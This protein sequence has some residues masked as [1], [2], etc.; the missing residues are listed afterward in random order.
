[1]AAEVT[2][3]DGFRVETIAQGQG[4]FDAAPGVDAN[5]D[6]RVDPQD[7]LAVAHRI[8]AGA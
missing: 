5:G 1:V 3:G 2:D 8:F 7:R 6:G 4:G